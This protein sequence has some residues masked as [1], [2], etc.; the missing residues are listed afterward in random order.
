RVESVGPQVGDELL[1]ADMPLVVL[2]L[3]AARPP[4]THGGRPHSPVSLERLAHLVGQEIVVDRPDLQVPRLH[5]TSSLRPTRAAYV[6]PRGRRT[7]TDERRLATDAHGHPTPDRG[8][9]RTVVLAG[10]LRLVLG[11]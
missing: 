1:Q 8:L 5:R 10:G 3:R 4:R 11:A 2:H 9:R 6:P 7:P